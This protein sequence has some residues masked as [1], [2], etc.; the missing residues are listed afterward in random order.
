[1]IAVRLATSEDIDQLVRIAEEMDRF[2]GAVDFEPIEVRQRQIVDALSV[3]RCLLASEDEKVVGFAAYSFLW[4]AVGMSKSIFLKELY[5]SP[6]CQ[7]RGVGTRLMEALFEVAR[8]EG[9]SRVE[10]INDVDNKGAQALYDELGFEPDNAK[11]FYRVV[12]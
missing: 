10:W 4:P 12:P 8:V 5:V 7:R 11:V 1:M 6:T 9:C 3:A 2:Y